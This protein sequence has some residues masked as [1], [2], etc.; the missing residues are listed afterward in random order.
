MAIYTCC[1]AMLVSTIGWYPF[2]EV[3]SN[4]LF[5]EVDLPWLDLKQHGAVK[6]MMSLWVEKKLGET[7]AVRLSWSIS[8][9]TLMCR[10]GRGSFR[11]PFP[12]T[13]DEAAQQATQVGLKKASRNITDVA[14]GAGFGHTVIQI[15]FHSIH[16]MYIYTVFTY[17]HIYIYL[18][19]YIHFFLAGF[20]ISF[21]WRA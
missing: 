6:W 1:M 20:H 18:Y 17:L 7:L 13:S 4:S 5:L 14:T 21:R 9:L 10:P 12:P 2:S 11:G 8:C 19:L 15:C 16:R 3:M